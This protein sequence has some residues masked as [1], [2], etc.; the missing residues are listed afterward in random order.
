[1]YGGHFF[2]LPRHYRTCEILL[3]NNNNIA[4]GNL[5]ECVLGDKSELL[6]HGH[7]V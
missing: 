5:A 2:L 4:A 1:M 7:H 3:I 6:Q